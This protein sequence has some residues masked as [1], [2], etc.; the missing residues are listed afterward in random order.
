MAPSFV[1]ENGKQGEA[2][3]DSDRLV[4]PLPPLKVDLSGADEYAFFLCRA[5]SLVQ[6][7]HVG[8]LCNSRQ[9]PWRYLRS[10]VEADWHALDYPAF[11][12]ISFSHSCSVLKSH[13]VIW[14]SY[15]LPSVF[16]GRYQFPHMFISYV[17]IT[18]RV[19][20]DVFVCSRSNFFEE[21]ELPEYNLSMIL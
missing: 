1:G 19:A 5:F 3:S 13:N 6:V 4:S 10:V 17:V 14:I 11:S 9:Q 12:W 7:W 15:S 18:W 16:N 2:G 20:H 21:Q 8:L